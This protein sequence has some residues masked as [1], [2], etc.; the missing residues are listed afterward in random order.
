[1]AR[2]AEYAG[3]HNYSIVFPFEA[4]YSPVSARKWM[5]ENWTNGFY[6]CA[7]Y[8]ALVFGIR[9]L[10]R[11]RVAFRLKGPLILWNVMLSTF[12][13]VGFTRTAPELYRALSAYGLHHSVCVAR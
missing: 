8:V 10:M 13:I 6:V 2:P 12:S 4:Q 9:R 11:D 5:A 1:M 7:V 3:P